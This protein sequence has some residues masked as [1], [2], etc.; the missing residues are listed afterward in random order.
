M[1]YIVV[2]KDVAGA[3]LAGLSVLCLQPFAVLLHRLLEDSPFSAT[4]K[5][6]RLPAIRASW[7]L[8]LLLLQDFAIK[9]HGNSFNTLEPLVPVLPN[10]S[11][12]IAL[13]FE[14]VDTFVEFAHT[15]GDL[16]GSV[17]VTQVL[18][19]ECLCVEVLF[20]SAVAECTQQA[21]SYTLASQT[22]EDLQLGF[23]VN[24]M[25]NLRTIDT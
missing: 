6:A 12:F 4:D 21:R 8:G 17:R 19:I 18:R 22:A 3:Q 2:G 23:A 11:T 9:P 5:A 1:T 24:Q 10:E 13:T 14:Q 7:L 25:L 16:L 20:E 15:L